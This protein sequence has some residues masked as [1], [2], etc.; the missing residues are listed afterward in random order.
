LYNQSLPKERQRSRIM[1]RAMKIR[2]LSFFLL[3]GFVLGMFTFIP[4][5]Q[6]H[7]D[8]GGK[9][10]PCPP[11]PSGGGGG[12]RKPT[13]TPYPSFTP[14]ATDTNTPVPM[15][16][17]KP[18]DNSGGVVSS[19]PNDGGNVPPE[20]N[21]SPFLPSFLGGGGLSGILIGL[22]VGI[23]IG[24]LLPAVLRGMTGS[25]RGGII[26]PPNIPTGNIGQINPHGSNANDENAGFTIVPPAAPSGSGSVMEEYNNT[27]TDPFPPTPN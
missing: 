7:A 27:D 13:P 19:N 18:N 6:V 17:P 4:S 24:L 2:L 25:V 3:A 21:G 9:Y 5:T 26:E 23:L 15:D 22:L 16:T 11:Q 12:K 8:C 20:P 14:T 10:P 1:E